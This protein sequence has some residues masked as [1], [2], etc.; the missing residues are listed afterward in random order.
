MSPEF[1]QINQN[2]SSMKKATQNQTQKFS[3]IEGLNEAKGRFARLLDE[4]HNM[5]I[6]EDV[7]E[8]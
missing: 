3:I 1:E 8:V 5:E 2:L 7:N 6:E 4:F